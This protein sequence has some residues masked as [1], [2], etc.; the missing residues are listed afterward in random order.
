MLPSASGPALS[1]PDPGRAGSGSAALLDKPLLLGWL[2]LGWLLATAWIRPLALPDEGRYAGVAWEMVRSGHWLTPTLD[3]L[4]YFHKPPLLYWLTA[5]SI[6]L[7]GTTELGLRLPSILG[8]MLA[9]GSGFRLLLRWVGLSEA[10][11]YLLAL[12]TMP[13]FYGGS[14]YANHDMLVAGFISTAIAFAADALL[15]HDHGQPWKRSMLLAWS[16]MALGLL[17]KGLIGIVLPSGVIGLWLLMQ[18]RWQWVG[19]LMWWPGPLLFIAIAAPWFLLMQQKFPQ[20]LHYFFVRQQFERFAEHGFNNVQPFWFYPAVLALLCLPWSPLLLARWKLPAARGL[21]SPLR[22]LQ[23]TWVA[24]IALFFSL[25]ASKLVGYILPAVPA[26]AMLVAEVLNARAR[27]GRAC[28][29]AA[30]A[31]ALAGALMVSA[32][33]GVAWHDP[34]SSHPLAEAWRAQARPGEPLMSLKIYRFDLPVYARLPAPVV[35]LHHWSEPSTVVGDSW[36]RELADAARFDPESG[37]HVLVDIDHLKELLCA[38]P[39][40]WIIANEG[41]QEGLLESAVPVASNDH[42]RLLR[43]DREQSNLSCFQGSAN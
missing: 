27:S 37:A 18:R 1:N 28:A 40:S 7:F 21:R 17:S 32:L 2:L 35:V 25:P 16:A 39:V 15:A 4:P 22:R 34:H 10:R 20:F 43:F 29:C 41:E 30:A 13:L 23:W 12:A 5:M 8:A 24:V 3:G 26:V 14:Q 42:V 36:Q 11:W 19:K 33:V 31:A 38:V 9:A 6:K